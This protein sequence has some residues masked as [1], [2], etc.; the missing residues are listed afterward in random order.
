MGEQDLQEQIASHL[1]YHT[2]E[3]A[4]GVLTPGWFDLRPVVD[5]MPWP[6]VAGKRCLDVGTYDGFLAFELERR[7]ASEVIAIDIDDHT[8]WDWPPDVR[9]TGGENLAR[10]AG[11]EKGRG[12]RIAADALSSSVK[13]MPISVYDLDPSEVGTF[14]VVVCGSLMLH[15]RDPLRALE[16]IRGVCTGAFLSAE[17]IDADLTVLHPKR[18]V[19]RLN[20]SG[21]LC[22]WWVPNVAGHRRMVFAAGFRID[23]RTRPY[24]VPYGRS[25]PEPPSTWRSLRR[26]AVKRVA[27]GSTPGVPHAAVLARPRV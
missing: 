7:G 13:R 8:L 16:A 18:P 10:L 12:F 4:P 23:R 27:V 26:R 21:D 3:L 1:W 2:I 24:P 9:A 14:D 22:Q 17:E 20:G 25:H 19:A 15:L 6:D 11:P 5:R